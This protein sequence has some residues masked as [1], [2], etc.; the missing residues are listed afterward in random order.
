MFK[1][2][3]YAEDTLYFD[4]TKISLHPEPLLALRSTETVRI[5]TVL[6]EPF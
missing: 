3:L 1:V 6:E 4:F 5:R 2:I